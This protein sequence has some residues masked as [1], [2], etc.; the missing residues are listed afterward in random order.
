MSLLSGNFSLFQM[1]QYRQ[2][3]VPE[4]QN[5]TSDLPKTAIVWTPGN[6]DELIYDMIYDYVTFRKG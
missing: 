2:M 5:Y 4:T 3:S 6:T 1:Y